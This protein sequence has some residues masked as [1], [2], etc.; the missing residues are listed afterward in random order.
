MSQTDL[1]QDFTLVICTPVASGSTLWHQVQPPSL[2]IILSFGLGY[3]L[4]WPR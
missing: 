4:L 3:T 1:L 2:T